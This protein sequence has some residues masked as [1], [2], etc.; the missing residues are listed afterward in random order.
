MKIYLDKRIIITLLIVFVVIT[1]LVGYSFINSDISSSTSL[2]ISKYDCSNSYD[3][4][5]LIACQAVPDNVK[6]KYVSSST[7]I[8]FSQMSSN[9]NGK[10]V[11][12]L[13]ST[14]GDTYPIHYFRGDVDN[15]YATFGG[16][17]WRIVRTTSNGGIKLVYNG[18]SCNDTGNNTLIDSSAFNSSSDSLAYL[19]YMYGDVYTSNNMNIDNTF[20]Y[21]SSFSFVD[22][23]QNVSGDG[24]Y[25]LF[26]QVN[27]IDSTHHYT[28]LNST[29]TCSS[30]AYV[31][32]MD[33]TYI[34]YILIKDGKNIENAIS[35]M[36]TNTNSST[37]KLA[38][39]NSSAT[40][41]HY[42]SFMEDSIWCNDRSENI[43]TSYSGKYNSGWNYNGGLL[44]TYYWTSSSVRTFNS[45]RPTIDCS[46]NNDKFARS[47]LLGGNGNLTSSVGL[48]TADEVIMAGGA[49]NNSQNNYY[50][51]NSVGFWTMTP[52]NY[53][54]QVAKNIVV[55][56][57]G[58]L[59]NDVV[60]EIYGV[61]PVI[62][63][64]SVILLGGDGTIN[65]PYSIKTGK[66]SG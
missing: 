22:V 21:G 52:F 39:D 7:G 10:G 56:N 66:H 51:N 65:N 61:R 48:L 64:S 45:Y 32:Y 19:G 15:N 63:S 18:T 62:V 57:N 44:N 50:L 49:S 54:G 20:K 29:G 55:L 25:T 6:S 40:F 60:S 41:S 33:D 53:A 12:T 5:Q 9:T 2:S 24:T 31:Y 27:S 46:S 28:C 8:N 37:I 14:I 42:L 17:C 11:Y 1:G 26:G 4:Y 34:Y 23:D 36:K 43:D 30:I 35:E 59:S 38:M 16:Y 13:A 3:L 58:Q 47:T